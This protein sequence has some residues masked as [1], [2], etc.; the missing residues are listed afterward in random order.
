M[1]QIIEHVEG[2]YEA[3]EVPFGKA[4]EWHPAY[5]TLECD[6]GEKL[7]LPLTAP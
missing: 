6:C 3:S 5:V 1:T 4:Y 7:T 2:H